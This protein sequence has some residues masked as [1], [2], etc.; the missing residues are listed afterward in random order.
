MRSI[1][2]ILGFL[3]FMAAALLLVRAAQKPMSLAW[4]MSV[5]NIDSS[6]TWEYQLGEYDPMDTNPR[7][8]ERRVILLSD[9]EPL[10]EGVRCVD[11]DS[12]VVCT[13]LVLDRWRGVLVRIR[14]VDRKAAPGGWSRWMPIPAA[15]K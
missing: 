10:G 15:T 4:N 1:A 14:G 2:G 7:P 13:T 12:M 8:E 9:A 5:D 11:A 6:T 3:I